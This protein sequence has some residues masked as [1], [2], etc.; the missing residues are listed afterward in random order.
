MVIQK[1]INHIF[2]DNIKSRFRLSY[3]P[4]TEP[5]FEVDVKCWNCQKGCNI[6]KQSGWIEILGS[7]LLH[8][9]VLKSVGVNLKLSGLAA[10]IGIERLAMIKNEIHDIREFYENDFRFNDQFKD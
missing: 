5:S 2:S 6:C 9:V 7:G 3:F 8:P 4:F 1:F 10:G